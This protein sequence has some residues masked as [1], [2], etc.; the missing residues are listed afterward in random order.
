MTASTKPSINCARKYARPIHLV[1]CLAGC[2]PI[3]KTLIIRDKVVVPTSFTKKLNSVKH[4]N[5]GVDD[6]TCNMGDIISDCF[7]S[8]VD[9]TL[10]GTVRGDVHV[11]LRSLCFQTID[12]QMRGPRGDKNFKYGI[13][14]MSTNT[15]EIKYY[16]CS[17]RNISQVDYVNT[18]DLLF[19]SIECFT[20][21]KN[22]IPQRDQYELM[23]MTRLSVRKGICKLKLY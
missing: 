13:A 10:C 2:P 5:L 18:R 12:I 6:I 21:K 22:G 23:S 15:T 16:M 11:A 14:F 17:Y 19:F 9:S 8:L 4:L 3:L 7:P 20:E 1:D